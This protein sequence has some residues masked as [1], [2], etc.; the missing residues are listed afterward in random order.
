VTGQDNVTEG[1][2]VA[3]TEPGRP[4]LTPGASP[5]RHAIERRSA[6]LLVTISTLPRAIPFL[7][8]AGLFAGGILLDGPIA[9]SCLTLLLAFFGWLLYL[10]WPALPAGARAVRLAVVAILV[11]GVVTTLVR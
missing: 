2:E 6:R 4:F 8:V 9:A 1:A 3:A 5:T 11:A 7:L 10:S